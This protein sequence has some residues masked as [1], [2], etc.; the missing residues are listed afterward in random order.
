VSRY[1]E[2]DPRTKV[3]TQ[4]ARANVAFEDVPS[5]QPRAYRDY[6]P[7][8][9]L[10]DRDL[11]STFPRGRAEIVAR[12]VLVNRLREDQNYVFRVVGSPEHAE[13]LRAHRRGAAP[14]VLSCQSPLGGPKL[15]LSRRVG[16]GYDR[17][18]AGSTFTGAMSERDPQK[19]LCQTAAHGGSWEL[20]D[21]TADG[22]RR[23][24]EEAAARQRFGS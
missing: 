11:G 23:R 1:H 17:G 5:A 20:K 21:H 6:E 24:A 18:Q 12:S 19:A 9:A 13:R 2:L 8:C 10:L 14:D 4:R 16:G 15:G 3:N 7:I 22:V